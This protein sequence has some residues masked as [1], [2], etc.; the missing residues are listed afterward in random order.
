MPSSPGY[1]RNY[2]QENKYKAKPEQIAKRV[3]RN[4]AR[5]HMI[6]K[7]K[8]K[9]GDGLQVDHKD[10]NALNNSPKNLR[11]ISASKNTSYPRTK[12]ARKK[13]AGD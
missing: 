7:G 4:K 3:A 5:R 10:G 12:T 6:A 2:Q 1:K 8:A 9:L 11:V 13:N